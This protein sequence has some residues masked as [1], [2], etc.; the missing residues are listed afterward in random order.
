MRRRRRLTIG[1]SSGSTPARLLRCGT[2][3]LR[4]P[5]PSIVRR[6]RPG[7]PPYLGATA[8]RLRRLRPRARAASSPSPFRLT[9]DHPHVRSQCC[10][11][12][13]DGSLGLRTD[14]AREQQD[15]RVCKA[16]A[17]V[18]QSQEWRPGTAG[19]QHG[20]GWEA[21]AAVRRRAL[22]S[23]EIIRLLLELELS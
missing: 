3:T 17:V 21:K 9:F 20:C 19:Q 5:R 15:R 11:G 4:R 12:G 13:S 6:R 1:C 18:G 22:E 23:R 10:A 8:R 7:R 14:R 2:V 16:S